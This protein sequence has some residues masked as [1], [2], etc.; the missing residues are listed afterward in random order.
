M[1]GFLG[2]IIFQIPIGVA[3]NLHTI[4]I[5]RFFGGAFGSA[6]IGIVAGMFVDFWDTVSRSIATMGYAAAVFA[7]PAMGPIVGE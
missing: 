4:M 1:I 2:F 3:N 5:C 7:G 6:P